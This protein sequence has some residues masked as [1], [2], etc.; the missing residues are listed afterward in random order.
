MS[1]GRRPDWGAM[2]PTAVLS[3]PLKISAT[4]ERQRHSWIFLGKSDGDGNN[5]RRIGWSSQ[6]ILANMQGATLNV[7]QFSFLQSLVQVAERRSRHC[8]H[9]HR[10]MNRQALRRRIVPA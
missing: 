3:F 5:D 7:F 9:G 1:A 4:R 6:F 8:H 2:A 10:E